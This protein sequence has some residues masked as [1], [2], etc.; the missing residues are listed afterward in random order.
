MWHIHLPETD[1]RVSEAVLET[2]IIAE[3]LIVS[4]LSQDSKMLPWP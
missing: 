3:R 2:T 1:I 4:D